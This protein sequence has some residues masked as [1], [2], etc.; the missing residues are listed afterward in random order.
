M[1]PLLL[2]ALTIFSFGTFAAELP[3]GTPEDVGMSSERLE[4]ITDAV[5]RHIDAGNV[6][7][8]VVGVAR[9]GQVVY[10]QAHGKANVEKNIPM[11][12]DSLFQMWSSTKP[13]LGVAAMMMIEQGLFKATDPVSKYIPEFE[14]IQVAVLKVPVEEDISPG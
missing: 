7:G 11:S 6:Q 5:Q 8:A 13:V 12:T 1:R 10:L 3:K 2:A 9:R 14:G 4:R